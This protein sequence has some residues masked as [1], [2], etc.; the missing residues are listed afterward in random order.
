MGL[1][2]ENPDALAVGAL[3]HDIG[4]VTLP[5]ELI[6]KRASFTPGEMALYQTHSKHGFDIL[7]EK[8][9]LSLLGAH[10]AFQHHEWQNGNGYPRKL[11]GNHSNDDRE[12][13]NRVCLC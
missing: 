13:S 11:T 12:I 7:R 6:S 9:E 8:R 2:K 5:I 3:I 4:T 10:I 1:D